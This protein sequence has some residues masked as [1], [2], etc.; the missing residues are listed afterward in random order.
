VRLD[1]LTHQADTFDRKDGDGRA[2]N[3]FRRDQ[4]GIIV[5]ARL[6][7]GKASYQ[8]SV[9][10]QALADDGRKEREHG[11]VFLLIPVCLGAGAA[12][13]F[14]LGTDPDVVTLFLLTLVFMVMRIFVLVPGR[15]PR[16]ISSAMV[17]FLCGMILAQIQTWR[18]E[19]VILDSPV[20]TLVTG[21][22]L[23]RESAGTNRWRYTLEVLGTSQPALKR[24]PLKIAAIVRGAHLAAEVGSVLTGKARLSPPSGP[25]L[26]GLNDF[27]F[28]AF[29]SGIGAIGY[30]YGQPDVTQPTDA[31]QDTLAAIQAWL[32]GVRAEI[33]HRIQSVLAGDTGAFAV[34]IVTDDRRAIS[35]D[36]MDALRLAGLAHIIAISGLNM[37]LA[38]G[39]FL[40]SLRVLFS[41]PQ[42][43][44]HRFNTKKWAATGALL[45]LTAYFMISGGAVSAERAFIMMAVILGAVLVDRPSISLRNVALSAILILV[46]DPAA[47]MGPSFQMSFAATLALVAGY[48]WW[49][50][51]PQSDSRFSG[52]PFYPAVNTVTRFFGGIILTSAIGGFSTMV[53]SIEH[54][55]RVATYG[56]PANL[57]A[58]PIVSFI[59]MPAAV[60]AMVAM[61]F[62]LEYLPLKVMGF[63][64]DA[65]IEIARYIRSWGGEI[66]TG[67]PSAWFLPLASIF[68][69]LACF[70]RTRLGILAFAGFLSVCGL[71]W[72]IGT[73]RPHTL[74]VSEDGRLA[75]LLTPDGLHS[76]RVRPS[77]FIFQ[78]W[79]YALAKEEHTGP[80]R[81]A[82]IP[83]E[84]PENQRY[85]TL[86]PQQTILARQAMKAALDGAGQEQFVCA[87]KQWCVTKIQNAGMVATLDDTSFLDLACEMADLV[88]T[89]VRLPFSTCRNGT[90]LIS[91]NDLRVHGA[92][93]IALSDRVPGENWSFTGAMDG[94]IRPWTLHRSYDWKSDSYGASV[95]ESQW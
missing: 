36:T 82:P 30:F 76:N 74:L 56:L 25:A 24:P 66:I 37:A 87:D 10:F 16:D 12:T 63:G 34:S 13:W 81:I 83:L 80:L 32:N 3:P 84:K 21:K 68:L 38:A 45:A 85:V 52:L 55:H 95:P 17:L 23:E 42:S 40:V 18:T 1:D 77:A 73:A 75:A 27:A 59:V 49:R 51:R 44:M 19:T 67:Q 93:E 8:I 57:A 70:A 58:M 7:A 79:Q 91:G 20:T 26:P 35:K 48:G 94:K 6:F 54:F 61:P 47:V 9:W 89:P 28:D 46:I 92:L 50:K 29:F 78:Q 4:P 2:L 60:V 15:W 14:A 53:F 33:S 64:L 11:F 72:W 31:P 90:E 69:A 41:I 39:I 62:G 5:P 88:I 71:Q 43:F 22:V 65:T 86:T